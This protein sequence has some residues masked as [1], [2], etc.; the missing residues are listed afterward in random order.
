MQLEQS[1]STGL[2]FHER[3]LEHDLG[4]GHPESAQRLSTVMEHL[5]SSGLLSC[6]HR[7]TPHTDLDTLDD[8]IA[9]IHCDEHIESV[10]STGPT[11]QIARLAVAGVVQAVDLIAE[12]VIRNAFCAVRPPGHHAHNNGAHYEGFH[13][14]EGFC[15][16]NN[17]AIAARYAQKILGF[18]SI[19]ILDW[20][21]HHGNGTEWAFYDDPSVFFFS[22]H[23]L[24]T[25]PGT[26]FANRNGQGKGEG[27]SVSVPLPP[28]AGDHE[29]L[30]AWK[31]IL[32]P[33]LERVDFHPDFVMVSAGFD[34]RV[35]DYLGTLRITDD[36]FAAL[37]DIA[38][39]LADRTADGRLLSVL[40][41]GYDPQGL[42]AAVEVHLHH[43][44]DSQGNSN[45]T[46]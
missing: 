24:N 9:M 1:T 18:K 30:S 13:Q 28:G 25:Y 41:G 10:L 19:L 36:G 21:Y 5:E 23:V 31:E 26:G 11:G 35:G 40:E 27:F 45:A 16:F 46:A 4:Y 38:I 43:L 14:G 37:T 44:L 42:A 22:T 8:Y 20:D 34:G 12:G 17:V 33:A 15:F 6:L 3:F 32:F 7:I 29:I 39:T 2:V